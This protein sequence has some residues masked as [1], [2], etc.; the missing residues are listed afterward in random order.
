MWRSQTSCNRNLQETEKEK[1][2]WYPLYLESK[3]KW[4]KWTFLQ[5]RGK[6]AF[7]CGSGKEGWWRSLGRTGTHCCIENGRPVGT[8]C[9]EQGALLR[10]VWQPGLGGDWRG[11]DRCTYVCMAE[12]LLGLPETHNIVNPLISIQN[13]KLKQKQKP[14]GFC[15]RS[16][17]GSWQA[18]SAPCCSFLEASEAATRWL[19]LHTSPRAS[20]Q[21][22]LFLIYSNTV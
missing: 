8:Y 16:I 2:D 20:P 13:R 10:A 6:Q 14:E 5:K 19:S 11:T 4:Y 7:G 12:S 21:R 3:K 9:T 17:K 22:S 15:L 18:G 1:C